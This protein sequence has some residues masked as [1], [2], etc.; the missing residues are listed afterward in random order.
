MHTCREIVAP[1]VIP[2]IYCLFTAQTIFLGKMTAGIGFNIQP[3]ALPLVAKPI[4]GWRVNEA[5]DLQ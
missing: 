3:I 2:Q 5:L 1:R 4:P